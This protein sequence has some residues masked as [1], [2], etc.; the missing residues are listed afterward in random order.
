MTIEDVFKL[1]GTYGFPTVLSVYLIIRLD[2][3]LKET[4]KT[5]KTLAVTISSE[6]KDIHIVISQI[7]SILPGK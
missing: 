5:N 6:L 7:K 3:F 4:V 2:F 1:L